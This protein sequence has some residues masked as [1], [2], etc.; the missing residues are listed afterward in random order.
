MTL[1]MINNEGPLNPR[2]IKGEFR[3][4]MFDAIL[5]WKCFSD[6]E[7]QG[8][9]YKCILKTL[10]RNHR[11]KKNEGKGKQRN[12]GREKKC[13]KKPK[14]AKRDGETFEETSWHTH[15]ASLLNFSSLSSLA[16]YIIYIYIY[17]YI[18]IN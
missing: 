13:R 17:I 8:G 7:V 3:R 12:G 18:Y 4:E 16:F 11:R 9:P 10:G 14:K 2:K 1:A 15:A 5:F 6:L